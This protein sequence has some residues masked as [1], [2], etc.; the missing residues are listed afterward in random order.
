MHNFRQRGEK[1]ACVSVIYE[2]QT[3]VDLWMGHE[4]PAGHVPWQADTVLPLFSNTKLATAICLHQ[5]VD[6]GL[7]ALDAPVAEYW[8]A[9]AQNGK[10][11]IPVS[12]L[13]NH[14]A[15]LPALRRRVRNAGYTDWD[16]MTKAL[17]RE[18]PFWEP[19]TAV[20]YHMVNFGWL[21]GELVRR[22]SGQ[23][24]GAYFE[25]HV[26]QPTGTDFYIGLPRTEYSRVAPVTLPPL[27]LRRVLTSPFLR[28]LLFDKKSIP[29][30]AVVNTGRFTPNKKIYWPAE[31]GGAGGI[32][33]ARGLANMLRP[34]AENDGTLLSP[35]GV[36]RLA[37]PSASTRRDLTLTI[38]TRFSL[39]AMLRMDN[40]GPSSNGRSLRI[41]D[42]AFGHTGIGG[43]V[44][45][46]D[47]G[48]RI[49]FS[50]GMTQL[51]S[52][53]FV[54]ERGQSLIDAVYQSLGCPKP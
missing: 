9:F 15:G 23:S 49:A 46:A 30:L 24:L 12:A 42:G 11:D 10:A 33:N 5:L 32:G 4:D 2:G 29:F 18:T 19:G 28:K 26:R 53:L 45:F 16:Y 50:Y 52:G 34:L 6:R 17:E 54:N 40:P 7:V 14:T 31:I 41:P 38:P 13:L 20:G 35:E 27:T 37:T 36:D 39:G 1:G 21:V 22:I 43:S 3:V 51:G 44:S 8:P 48:Q 25:Q 47:P